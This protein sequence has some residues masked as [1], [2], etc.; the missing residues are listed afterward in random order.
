[1]VKGGPGTDT[2]LV[3]PKDLVTGCERKR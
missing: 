2:C 3:D 1:V